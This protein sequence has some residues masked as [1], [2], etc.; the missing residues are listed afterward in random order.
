MIFGLL[1]LVM[2]VLTAAMLT[3]PLLAFR[4][5]PEISDDLRDM[6]IYRAQLAEVENDIARGLLTETEAAETRTE[7]KRRMLA[8]AET[9][10]NNAAPPARKASKRARKIS[11]GLIIVLLP[12]LAVFIYAMLGAPG[13]P[14]EPY[15]ARMQ[16]PRFLLATAA[17]RLDE[18]LQKDPT[19]QE[20][21]HFGDL[22]YLLQDYADSA[23]AYRKAIASGDTA[24]A[25]WSQM[26]ETVVLANGGDVVPQAQEDF[27]Q[28]LR[29]DR[30]EPRALFYL[31]LAAAQNGNFKTAVAVWKKLQNETPVGAPWALMLE[32]R[33]AAAARAGKFNPAAITPANP[34]KPSAQG[35]LALLTAHGEKMPDWAKDPSARADMINAMVES[36]AVHLQKDRRDVQ[37]WIRLVRSYRVLGETDKATAA[38]TQALHSNPGNAALEALS[39]ARK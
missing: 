26:A 3:R 31:G 25:L 17:E 19:P 15:A 13:L 1:I 28:A 9:Q 7:I 10:E 23:A 2:T 8:A 24:P 20:Y 22:L 29:R 11:A 12:L 16:N 32:N 30:K 14:D 6:G 18:K 27:Y 34:P 33:I 37:G 36:L 21:K 38:L 4:P 5:E 39:G 35:R